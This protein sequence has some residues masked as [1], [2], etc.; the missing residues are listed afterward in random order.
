MEEKKNISQTQNNQVLPAQLVDDIKLIVE[1]GLREA[2]RSV[3]SVSI[4]TYW[5][6]GKRI[7]EEEQHGESRAE[8]GKHLIDLLSH[9]LSQTYPKGYSPRNLRDYRQFYLCFND[10]EIWHSRVPN[11]TWTHFRTLLSVTSEDARYWYVQE[12]SRQSWSVRTL[13]RNVGSQ[14]YFRLLQSPQK[15]AV[16]NEMLQLTESLKDELQGFLKDPVVAEFLQ[17]PSNASFT[18]TEL[19]KAIIRHLKEFLLE[20]GRGFA[21]M[22][23]QYHISSDGGDYFVDLVFYN[24]VL[25]CYV[26]IDLKTKKLTHQ[27]VGQMDMYVRMFDDLKRTDGDNP[28]IGLLL[29]SDTSKDIAKYSVLHDSKQLF[30]AKYLTYLPTEEVLRREI[31]QQKELFYLQHNKSNNQK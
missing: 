4:L 10:L 1:H 19:E 24:V 22:A 27:D 31:E 16:I 11:L 26:L 15:E 12:A 23:E 30:A 6:V 17:L 13:A 2:Y 21:F 5:N 7:V 25:K 8:Y 29:C 28:T 9:E 18:E 14:Y 20:M 3:N